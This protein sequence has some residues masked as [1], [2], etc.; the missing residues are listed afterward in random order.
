MDPRNDKKRFR[1]TFGVGSGVGNPNTFGGGE[2]GA[3]EEDGKW[4]AK[5]KGREEDFLFRCLAVSSACRR[6][7]SGGGAPPPGQKMCEPGD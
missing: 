5:D 3:D 6:L 1:L 4:G 2:K 7:F